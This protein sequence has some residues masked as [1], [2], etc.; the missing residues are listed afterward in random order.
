MPV[1]V[2]RK[3]RAA[4]FICPS[5]NAIGHGKVIM[6]GNRFTEIF[7]WVVF[8]FPG[9]IYSAWRHFGQRI[10]CAKC[11]ETELVL[12]DSETG[13]KIFDHAMR[14]TPKDIL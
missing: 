9:P 11:G 12:L 6:P 5:C 10:I 4:H 3:T 13:Q 8:L 1:K 14:T 7:L 2:N